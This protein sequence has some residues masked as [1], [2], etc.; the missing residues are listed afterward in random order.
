MTVRI[1]TN[2]ILFSFA[3][4]LATVPVL[5]EA[6]ETARVLPKKISRFRIVGVVTEGVSRTYDND[7][8]VELITGSLNRSVT[9]NDLANA[10]GGTTGEQLKTLIQTLN[11]ISPGS[12]DSLAGA[13]LNSQ[14]STQAQIFLPAFEYGLTERLSLGIRMPIEKRIVTN[15]FSANSVNNAAAMRA[16]VGALDATLDAGLATFSA[17]NF[18]TAFFDS[19][20]FASKGYQTPH[21]FS[22]TDPGDVEFGGKYNFYKS[23]DWVHSVLIGARAPTGKKSSL[24]DPFDKGTSKE[25]WGTAAQYLA[26]FNVG[27]VTLG[28][29]A[30]YTY[31]FSDTRDRAVPKDAN[32]SLPSL[33]PQDGQVLSVHR[34]TGNQLDTELSTLYTFPG[35]AVGVWGA[36]QYSDKATDSFQGSKPNLY[37][38]GLSNGTGWNQHMAEIGAQYSTIPAFRKGK[39]AVPMEVSLLYNTPFAGT[40]SVISPYTRL[41]LM[42]Y[43]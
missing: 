41:D 29:A 8:R 21:D 6:R 39:I 31:N 23:D 38:A 22:S 30:K 34:K 28:G 12:G 1:L 43:F 11:A 36:W 35:N 3:A 40:N 2:A 37:Y 5:S 42:V 10:A 14:F 25:C 24:T 4:V 17:Q 13:D 16:S 15:R 32:D 9:V 20:L 19:S 7:G 26:E 27:R 33:L 18:D